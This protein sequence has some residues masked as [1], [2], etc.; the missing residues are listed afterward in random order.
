M[1]KTTKTK[2]FQNEHGQYQVTIP[3]PVADALSLKGKTVE[4]KVDSAKSL[5]MVVVDE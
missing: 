1:P 2:V 4:W 5:R 3:K